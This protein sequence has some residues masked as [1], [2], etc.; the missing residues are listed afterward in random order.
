MNQIVSPPY[1]GMGLF[2]SPCSCPSCCYP[3][4]SPD[5]PP[6]IPTTR[7]ASWR[8]AL[9]SNFFSFFFRLCLFRKATNPQTHQLSSLKGRLFF[10]KDTGFTYRTGSPL[11]P[12]LSFFLRLNVIKPT[13]LQDNCEKYQPI[14]H[15]LVLQN[16]PPSAISFFSDHH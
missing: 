14:F 1:T 5:L 12:P 13:S 4:P 9:S 3:T 10:P 7:G 16:V 2:S 11:P 8:V 15:H 6:P